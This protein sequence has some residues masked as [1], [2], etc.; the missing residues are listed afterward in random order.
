MESFGGSTVSGRIHIHQQQRVPTD[1]RHESDVIMMSGDKTKE[2]TTTLSRVFRCFEDG[3]VKV[4]KSYTG[5]EK[6]VYLEKH[7]Y[8]LIRKSSYDKP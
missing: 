1:D 2:E 5:L 8:K 4:F 3:S 7:E 6:H